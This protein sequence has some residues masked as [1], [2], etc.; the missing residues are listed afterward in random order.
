[1]IALLGLLFE[2]LLHLGDGYVTD[3]RL[4]GTR[5]C[6][7]RR[8]PTPLRFELGFDCDFMSGFVVLTRG[9]TR[10]AVQAPSLGLVPHLACRTS[11]RTSATSSGPILWSLSSDCEATC[12]DAERPQV[13]TQADVMCEVDISHN[14]T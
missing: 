11:S 8:L 13:P 12:P 3:F 5:L 2:N 9:W 10:W 6:L 4:Y 1:M 14:S 7:P